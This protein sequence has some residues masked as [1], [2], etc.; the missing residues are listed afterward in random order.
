[1][2]DFVG[3]NTLIS[4]KRKSVVFGWLVS[5]SGYSLMQILDLISSNYAQTVRAVLK[6]MI[7]I[8]WFWYWIIRGD[9]WAL[10]EVCAQCHYR[11]FCGPYG[12]IK[13][14]ITQ[15]HTP[16]PEGLLWTLLLGNTNPVRAALKRCRV[17]FQV[18][19]PW[20]SNQNLDWCCFQLY[21]GSVCKRTESPKSHTKKKVWGVVQLCWLTVKTHRSNTPL[22]ENHQ[23]HSG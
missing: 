23:R 4:M 11:L 20:A 22:V 17:K 12:I 2:F 7:H 10:V 9:C 13:L 6:R 3:N 1:M 14:K 15:P 16:S 8:Y 18:R 19:C 5:V 21:V